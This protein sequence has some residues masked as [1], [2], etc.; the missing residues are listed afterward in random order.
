MDTRL[1]HGVAVV[2]AILLMAATGVVAWADP[3]SQVGRLNLIEGT[4]SFRPGTMD[5]WAPAVLNYPLTEGDQLWAEQG[6][7]AEM[8]VGPSAIRL[9][10]GTDFTFVALEDDAVQVRLSAGS[11]NL[12]LRRLD[13]GEIFEIDTPNAIVILDTAGSYRIDVQEDGEGTSVIARQGS[14]QIT[15]GN[16]MLSV[17]PGQE[18]YVSGSDSLAYSVRAAGAPDSL[19]AWSI[20]RDARE[21]SLPSLR[22]VSRE[23]I[24]VEDLDEYGTWV[25]VAAYGMVWQP[26]RVPAGWAPYH[27]GRW[28]WVE[29]WGWTWIDSAPWG[30]APFHYG[31]WANYAGRWVWVPG[32]VVARPVYAPALVVFVGGDAWRPAGGEGI[33][34]FPLGPREPYIPPFAAS[35]RYLQSVNS[36]STTVLTPE[37]I[38]RFDAVRFRWVN[39]DIPRAVTVV[40]RQAF[41]MSRPVDG[42]AVLVPQTDVVRAPVMGMTP[43]LVPQRESVFVQPQGPRA[44]VPRPPEVV[45]NRPVYAG[46]TPP[47]APVP[48]DARQQQLRANPGRPVDPTLLPGLRP[49][50][51]VRQ[52]PVRQFGAPP[53]GPQP[54]QPQQ[55]V[56]PQRPQPMQPQQQV[57][58]QRPQP[59][60]PQQPQQQVQPQRPQPQ[61][62]QQQVQ[63]QRPQPQQPQAQQQQQQV[64]PQRP[65][66]TQPQQQ[67]R[68]QQSQQQERPQQQQP[69]AQQQQQQTQPQAQSQ[70]GAG[71][72]QLINTLRTQSLPSV[73]RRLA[74]LRGK[75]GVKADLNAIQ[76]Q[77]QEARSFLS[78]ADSDVAQGRND[79]AMQKAQSAQQ[80]IAQIEAT[81]S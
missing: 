13:P 64:Q 6:S 69:Q 39:R 16:G 72:K 17:G 30:F 76:R 29:P 57:Q 58:P 78:G 21:D 35:A 15:A 11:V 59:T 81:L 60:Q 8:H 25:T 56:Q 14:V 2:A 51:P 48:F 26:P 63:P 65:Q 12:R 1:R 42:A 23:M 75:K 7:R 52:P 32:P 3:P 33:G 44:P 49:A 79:Q 55:Q 18:G 54:M 20:A 80:R 9:G 74:S 67:E 61:Q 50:V 47:V 66:P 31:R 41:I 28:A 71:A 34:W 45:M 22:W 38:T 40:P 43:P 73:E 62:P 70:Q 10:S 4:V 19:D 68:P 46:R 77:I 53:Q 24:G 37:T 5:D 36:G 27:F